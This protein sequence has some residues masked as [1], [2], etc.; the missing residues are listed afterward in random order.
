LITV[1]P[2]GPLGGH[3]IIKKRKV[4][5][6]ISG[7]LNILIENMKNKKKESKNAK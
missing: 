2:I 5:N 7:E 6:A 3:H 1:I 4:K